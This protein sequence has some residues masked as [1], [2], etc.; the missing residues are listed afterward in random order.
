MPPAR[1]GIANRHDLGFTGPLRFQTP[2]VIRQPL[3]VT[4][5]TPVCAADPIGMDRQQSVDALDFSTI[6]LRLWWLPWAS[7]RKYK[8]A[9]FGISFTNIAD[10]FQGFIG[11]LVENREASADTPGHWLISSLRSAKRTQHTYL[12]K[13]IAPFAALHCGQAPACRC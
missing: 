6:D 8:T 7:L 11:S 12:D 3:R 9:T 13:A 1:Q 4:S 2:R 10:R 5:H